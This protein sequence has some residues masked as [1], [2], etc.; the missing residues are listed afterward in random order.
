MR[1]LLVIGVSVLAA[2]PVLN[3]SSCTPEPTGPE[4]MDLRIHYDPDEDAA[5]LEWYPSV[6]SVAGFQIVGY[7]TNGGSVVVSAAEPGE[8]TATIEDV[9]A[10]ALHEMRVASLDAN[11]DAVEVTPRE[12]I[13]AEPA[14]E[15]APAGGGEPQPSGALNI[16][17]V[18][19]D[20]NRFPFIYSS[21]K[22]E[23]NGQ[24]VGDLTEQN[25]TITEDGRTQTDYFEVTP[26][27]SSGGVRMADIV[28]LIDTSGSMGGEIASVRNNA[29][30]FANA[31]DASDIDYRLGLVRFGNS[32][33]AN[34]G[35]IGGGLTADAQTFKNWVGTL[36][37]SGGHEPGFAAV[38]KAINS[39]NFR[40][41]AQKHFL[42][43]TDEDSDDRDKQSTINLIL[44]ND[45]TVHCAVNCGYGSSGSDYCHAGS[46]RDVSGGLLFSVAANYSQVLDEIGESIGNTYIVRYRS[47][48]PVLNGAE[49]LVE[50]TVTKDASSDS[51]QYSYIPG[52]APT[53]TRTPETMALHDVPLQVG[54]SP[55]ISVIATDSA[56]P[57]IQ[58]V[59][60]YART[61]GSDQ[62]YSVI[63][64]SAQGNDL[65][66]ATVPS[67]LVQDP[68]LEYYVRATD[69]QVTSS[70]PS[71][72]PDLNPY[73]IAVMP[74]E[75]PIIEHSPPGSWGAGSDCALTIHATDT[76][77]QVATVTVHY[78]TLGE[79]LFEETGFSCA[80]G[81]TD[82]TETVSIPGSAL[83]V[84]GAEY[85]IE[86]KDNFGTS[87][88]WP[89]EGAASPHRLPIG[90]DF[91]WQQIDLDGEVYTV[92]VRAEKEPTEPT[93]FV[94]PVY[95]GG[96]DEG[97]DPMAIAVVDGA[98]D[99]VTDPDSV[100]KVLAYARNSALYRSWEDTSADPMPILSEVGGFDEV[101]TT[102][103]ASYCF[104]GVWPCIEFGG[105]TPTSFRYPYPGN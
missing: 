95:C 88:Y 72:E 100:R 79:I 94:Y 34:P 103:P 14:P 13:Q 48:N 80:P 69:G 52:G 61:A 66:S 38:R 9:E 44:A 84:P 93:K 3:F 54:S 41:G 60:L 12:P 21:V 11:G 70:D 36:G 55:T 89:P 86:V 56:A 19:C 101:A 43:I 6:E 46:I 102:P 26:P 76:T 64:M 35:I 45:V 92:K 16:T 39:Y 99:T 4:T 24:P 22:V 62:A 75:L 7:D 30:A 40:P 74:N 8:R 104:F 31:L 83:R 18:S 15:E 37:A 68:G 73:E 1:F 42:V 10:L 65:F 91:V 23:E 97:F 63:P 85:Y 90:K 47:D 51:V 5:T 29:I 82:V 20:S 81:A 49:R 87:A 96:C 78:R 32:S 33:G 67:G 27:G 50:C 98:G 59:T 105:G 53:I 17:L 28:F 71:T 2:S 77:M 58:H 25:F 57:F